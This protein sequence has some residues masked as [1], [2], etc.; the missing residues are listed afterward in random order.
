MTPD[1]IEFITE[2]INLNVK[3][4][5]NEQNFNVDIEEMSRFIGLLLVSGYH[6]LLREIDY[7]STSSS[8]EAPILP[9]TISRERFKTTKRFLHVADNQKNDLIEG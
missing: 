7:W 1:I 9:R 8:R 5:K 2:Q 4:D 6:S 3:R